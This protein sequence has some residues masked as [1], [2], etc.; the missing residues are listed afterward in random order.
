MDR[1]QYLDVGGNRISDINSMCDEFFGE[2]LK[3]LSL[4][5][6]PIQNISQCVYDYW[7]GSN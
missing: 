3:Y 4:W 7:S 1:L 2:N 6:N 5:N